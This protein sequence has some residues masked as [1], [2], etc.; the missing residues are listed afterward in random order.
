MVAKE[1]VVQGTVFPSEPY[2]TGPSC[3]YLLLKN[4]QLQLVVE[5][6]EVRVHAQVEAEA[7]VEA[8]LFWDSIHETPSMEHSPGHQLLQ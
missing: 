6:V 4:E 1:V 3:Q 5:A 7:Q 2:P 8:V